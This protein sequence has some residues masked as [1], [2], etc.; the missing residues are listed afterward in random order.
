MSSA[1]HHAP[2]ADT[3]AARVK[4]ATGISLAQCYQCG[5]CAAGCPVS[6]EMDLTPCQVLRLLQYELPKYDDRVLRCAGIWLCL[7]C[8][9]CSTRCPQEV[10]IP[11]I[12]DVVRREAV[13]KG[14]AH[15]SSKDILA[16][17][18]A[19]LGEIEQHGR[20][21]E[22]GL[23]KTYKLKTGHFLKDVL[24]APKMFLKGKLGLTPHSVK[25]TAAV[26]RI[27]KRTL[28]KG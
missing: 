22:V 28:G 13:A 19:F 21:F 8:E 6:D 5:K 27:F 14:I 20:L 7:S 3:L 18:Q 1:S 11:K 24:L 4:A 17:H 10:E 16:F 15:P 25:D 2:Q 23:V 9:T 26:K 12:M